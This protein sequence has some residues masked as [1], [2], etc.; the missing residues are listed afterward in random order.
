[1]L[2]CLIDYIGLN[3]CGVY[4]T[5]DSGHYLTTLPGISIESMDKIADSDQI[6]YLG[7]WAD[8]QK[9]AMVRFYADVMAELNGC[10]AINKDCDYEALICENKDK[11]IQPLKYLLGNQLMLERIYSNRINRF[12]TI[13]KK[14][15][16]ELRDFYQV[17][18]EQAL[19][20]SMKFI[21]ISSC[22]LCCSGNP[23]T[24]TWL[25]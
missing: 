7:V 3:Y 11:L 12:T 16:E 20:R 25:P 15:A 18:Y 10:Y 22:E 13:D 4:E 19:K 2:V 1:M 21:D 14:Q 5:P 6:T 9:E 23:Q 24:V 8:V 17:E